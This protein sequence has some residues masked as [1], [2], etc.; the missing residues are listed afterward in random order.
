MSDT[1]EVVSDF[2]CLPNHRRWLLV[3]T[4]RFPQRSCTGISAAADVTG[5]TNNDNYFTIDH[6]VESAAGVKG[7]M[8]TVSQSWRLE[9]AGIYAESYLR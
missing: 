2:F 7:Q 4:M 3:S 6:F 9:V 5:D 8:G 1:K